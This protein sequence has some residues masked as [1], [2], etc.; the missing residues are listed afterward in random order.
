MRDQPIDGF[1]L[2]LHG[3][4]LGHRDLRGHFAELFHGLGGGQGAVAKIER[5]QQG[6]MHHEVG[7]APD[8]R[9]EMRVAAQ[10]EAEMAIIL[11]G[12]FRLRLRAQHHF[13]DQRFRLVA[14]HHRQD[15]IELGR[16]QRAL[17]GE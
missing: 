6:A 1:A 13:V 3:A 15:A 12:V 8:R 2:G 9:G 16:P 14:F 17:F 4:A 11:G 10:I 5:A 7:I